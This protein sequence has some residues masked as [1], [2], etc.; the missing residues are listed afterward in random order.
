MRR[1]ILL[2]IWMSIVACAIYAQE[3]RITGR[4]IS[5]DD[6]SALPGVNVVIKGTTNGTATDSDGNYSLSISR[7]FNALGINFFLKNSNSILVARNSLSG[8]SFTSII[9][10]S[11]CNLSP[12]K[13]KSILRFGHLRIFHL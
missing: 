2:T 10:A 8:F 6:G 3:R 7:T 12:V 9:D 13:T 1:K 4:V 5:N 11:P